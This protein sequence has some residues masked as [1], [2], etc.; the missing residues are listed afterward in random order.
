MTL[1]SKSQSPRVISCNSRYWSQGLAFAYCI[2]Y[3]LERCEKSG[4]RTCGALAEYL[5]STCGAL[6]EHL[7]STCGALAEHQNPLETLWIPF[8]YPLDT[9]SWPS[10]SKNLHSSIWSM[11]STPLHS[12]RRHLSI[13]ASLRIYMSAYDQWRQ[14]CYTIAR[15]IFLQW[16]D[17]KNYILR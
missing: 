2:T 14:H 3:L 9:I 6:A 5:R 16:K 15:D 4:V 10:Q 13:A 1:S 11:V 7:R 12:C 17:R 8:G